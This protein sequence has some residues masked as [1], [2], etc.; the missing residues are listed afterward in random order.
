MKKILLGAA[1]WIALAARAFAADL[2]PQTYAKAP[3]IKAQEAIYNW[4]GFHI[5]GHI[6]GAF[7]DDNSLIGRSGGRF[8]GG[9]EFG[10]DRQLASGWVLGAEVQVD[11]LVGSGGSP[12]F[13]GNTRVTGNNN[14]LASFTGRAG[15]ALG[16]VLLYGKLGSAFRDNGDIKVT[17]SG[18]PVAVVANG[19][20]EQGITAGA[21]L[22]YMFAPNWSAKAEYQYYTFGDTTLTTGPAAIVGKRFR[23]DT[24]TVK[25]GVDY[26][27]SLGG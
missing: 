6:G 26:R 23:D 27:F 25:L 8:F 22:E 11:G 10:F 14:V 4:T 9:A 2:P 5:G 21:G 20:H 16:P 3:A 19:H 7:N 24:H 18:A 17:T 1:A 12:L 15:Y 13:P